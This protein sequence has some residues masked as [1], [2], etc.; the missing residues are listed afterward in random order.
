[1]AVPY[2]PIARTPIFD[3]PRMRLLFLTQDFPPAVGGIQTYSAGL[4][5]ALVGLGVTVEVV[6]PSHPDDWKT[7]ASFPCPVHRIHSR[8]DLLPLKLLS[9]IRG[10]AD[11]FRPNVIACAQ[12]PLAL[13]ASRVAKRCGA[14][15]AIAAH[16]RELLNT[17]LFPRYASIRRHFVRSADVLLP[18]SHYTA[19]LL[20]DLGADPSRIHV[21]TNGVDTDAFQPEDASELR[22]TLSPDGKPLLLTVSR[23]VYR[24]GI[25][26]M[27]EALALIPADE[28]PIYAIAGSG[29]DQDRLRALAG[30]LDVDHSIR[31]LGRVPDADLRALYNAADVFALP[32]RESRPDVEGFGLVFLEAAAC[33]TPS[34][35]ATTGGMPDAVDDGVT[36]LLVP[37]DDPRA[38]AS[39][40]TRLCSD[41]RFREKLGDAAYSRA[42][43]GFTWNAVAARFITAVS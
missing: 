11:A 29:P 12:W 17:S 27:M 22:H 6:C 18:V 38:L 32:A 33:R 10:I 8:D 31:W 3:A 34:I 28:R 30:S 21:L 36:G 16:G 37:P 15:L 5:R 14:T 19:R 23:L 35:G 25:D 26:T 24:K 41:A 42:C 20:T 40:I 2:R 9:R 7:D 13:P 39:A 1:M 43:D 4:V